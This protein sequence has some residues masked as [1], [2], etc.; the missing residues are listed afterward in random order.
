[1]P[2]GRPKL[3][4]SADQAERNGRDIG[5]EKKH[6]EHQ[7]YHGQAG[8]C[9]LLDARAR[10]AAGDEEV[11]AHGRGEETDGQVHHHDDA[12][13]QGRDAHTGDDGQKYGHENDDGG[14]SLHEYAHDEQKHVDDEQDGYLAAGDAENGAGYGTGHV[15][16]GHDVAEQ[17]GHGHEHDDDGGGFA[18]FHAAGADLAEV[19]FTVEEHT[20]DEPVEG[21]HGRGFG[22]SHESAVNAAE[23]DDRNKQSPLGIPY[24]ARHR[25]HGT[26]AGGTAPV[27]PACRVVGIAHEHAAGKHAGHDAADEQIADGN[28]SRDAVHHEGVARRN[29][30]AYGAC[31]RHDGRRKGTAVAAFLHGRNGERA[32]GRHGGRAGTADGAEEHA[33]GHGGEGHASVHAAHHFIGKAEQA[34]GQA[35]R[36]H[37]HARRNE[38]G[39]GHDGEAVQRG[40]G[41][42]RKVLDGKRVGTENGGQG[43]HA[44]AYGNGHTRHAEHEEVTEQGGNRIDILRKHTGRHDRHGENRTDEAVRHS[45][46]LHL[47]DHG[48]HEAQAH[49]AEAE[50]QN[51]IGNEEGN[52]HG[53]GMLRETLEP[54]YLPPAVPGDGKGEG[55]KDEFHEYPADALKAGRQHLIHEVD[56]D[57]AA[58]ADGP[59]YGNIGYPDEDV[60]G[61]FLGPHGRARAVDEGSD[62]V[63]V[64]N[65][66]GDE[67]DDGKKA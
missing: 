4:G 36:A 59:A 24:G 28:L 3:S 60:A 55:K 35:A 25:S 57:G 29:H 49:E 6:D 20:H 26:G 14:Q 61:N 52:A 42:L 23:H 30:D 64:N 8:F 21:G 39:D 66:P 27:V 22:G 41:H 67:A 40:E 10:Y 44:E 2:Y 46:P 15:F 12:E 17:C 63:A 43:G 62:E 54:L 56:A 37:E 50:R 58:L 7:A 38:E 47:P 45:R 18:R 34:L 16:N 33:G 11:D 19:Q 65:L 9:D 1:M 51:E 53:R 5:D 13:V 48:L 31:R 32:Y